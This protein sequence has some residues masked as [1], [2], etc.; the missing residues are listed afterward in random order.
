MLKRRRAVLFLAL[1]LLLP[2]P[3]A[4]FAGRVPAARYCELAV[5]CLL[6][7][8]REGG[9]GPVNSMIVLFAAQAVGYSLLCW[10]AAWFVERC[11]RPLRRRAVD[12]TLLAVLVAALLAA[13][14]F[15][16]YVTPFGRAPRGNLW[17]ALT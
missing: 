1:F 11:L 2:L 8:V 3:L 17:E 13:V 14:A 5:L 15:D 4:M 6:V 7:R 10:L 9:G 16:V 12:L